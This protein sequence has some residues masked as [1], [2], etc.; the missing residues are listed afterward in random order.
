M[1]NISMEFV[2]IINTQ[3]IRHVEMRIGNFCNFDCSFCHSDFKDGS[4]R[5]L[6][7]DLYKKT[8]SNLLDDSTIPTLFTIQGGEPTLYA[9]LDEFL[10]FIK[11]KGGYVQLF[12]N[13]S[14]T[15]RWWT[16]FL[17]KKLIDRLIITHHP[18]QNADPDHTAT[19]L[20]MAKELSVDATCSVTIV[21]D[22]FEKSVIHADKIV[23][24]VS[25]L[26]VTIIP[27][28]HS[29]LSYDI[30]QVYTIE[31]LEIIKNKNKE[32]KGSLKDGF[33]VKTF[34]GSTICQEPHGQWHRR[35][36]QTMQILNENK[37]KGWECDA[38]IYR[39]VIETDEAYKAMCRVDGVIGK[40][41]EGNIKYFDKPTTCQI[42]DCFC[43]ADITIPKRKMGN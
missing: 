29:E 2:K 24:L 10:K 19:V 36:G 22:V 3:K 40:V 7:L 8:I 21:K 15:I 1:L 23:S 35:Y 12:S 26:E 6:S 20:N 41:S 4:R 32:F 16:E 39:L 33:V 43:G 42:N 37:F 13:G 14:R 34:F 30:H 27:V 25:N 17:P 31:Q 18:E 28:I 11:S 5:P 9:Q 38:G